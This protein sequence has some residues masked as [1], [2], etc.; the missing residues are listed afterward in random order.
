VKQANRFMTKKRALLFCVTV[1][2]GVLGWSALA[3]M[4]AVSLS[5][6]VPAALFAAASA[7][8]IVW[9]ALKLYSRGGGSQGGE[10]GEGAEARRRRWIKRCAVGMVVSGAFLCLMSTWNRFNPA[11][12]DLTNLCAGG[13]VLLPGIFLL[14]RFQ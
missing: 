4:N 6:V 10:A 13:L 3:Y 14:V 11:G 2:V 7:N 8:G 1:N 9:L 5:L 12:V